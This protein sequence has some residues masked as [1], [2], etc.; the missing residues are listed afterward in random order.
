MKGR[1]SKT[2]WYLRLRLPRSLADIQ[3]G[4]HPGRISSSSAPDADAIAARS[5]APGLSLSCLLGIQAPVTRM[6]A[7]RIDAAAKDDIV[8][9]RA[10]SDA[11][12]LENGGAQGGFVV[13][14]RQLD[15]S[16][17]HGVGQDLSA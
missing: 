4:M 14:E 17:T 12:A 16:E 3:A 10:G 1:I 5:D 13:V 2:H 6:A 11:E 15:F 7:A 8:F 9:Q